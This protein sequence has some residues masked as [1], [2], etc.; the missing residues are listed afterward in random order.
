MNSENRDTLI[1]PVEKNHYMAMVN[2]I[3]RQR[4][5]IRQMLMIMA[6]L[7]VAL[8][9]CLLTILFGSGNDAKY[10][11]YE[12]QIQQLEQQNAV[13]QTRVNELKDQNEALQEKANAATY[14]LTATER[15]L[16]CG[17]VM[18]EA[19]GQGVEGQM[20]VAQCIRNACEID[21][22]DPATAIERYQY[23]AP[24]SEVTDDVKRAVSAVF[25]EGLGYTDEAIMY[26]YAPDVVYSAWHETQ[27]YVLMH[28][29]HKFF[30]RS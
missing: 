29:D 19:G 21:G 6:L 25:D 27:D 28:G 5:T 14:P 12:A 20:L 30:K 15:E 17:V 7:I 1:V 18:A 9:F 10:A 11:E 26:F 16:I 23:A 3:R 4:K 24:K 22:I 2:Q 8:G 13:L